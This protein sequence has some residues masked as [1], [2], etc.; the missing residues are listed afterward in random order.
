MPKQ[1]VLFLTLRVFSATGGIEKVC[2]AAA[3]ALY[4][5][6]KQLPQQRDVQV[7]SMYDESTQIDSRYL[8]VDQFHGF[9][10]KRFQFMLAAMKAARSSDIVLLSHVNLLL[11]VP[12]IWLLAPRK[13][14]MLIAHGIE[15][16]RSLPNWKRFLLRRLAQILCVS[17]FTQ[18]QLTQQHGVS[19]NNLTVVWNG[20][21]PFL[22][23][24]ASAEEG[25]AFR[26]TL[27]IPDSALVMMTLTRIS[28]T[29]GYKGY[30]RLIELMPRLIE[31]YPSLYY[32]L[33][34]KHDPSEKA[35]L[36]QLLAQHGC[37]ERV[38]FTG[39]LPDEQVPACFAASDVYVMPSKKEGFGLVFIE[40]LFY[41]K[42]V[43]AGG[44]DGSV[45]ALLQGKL[46]HLV[47]PDHPESILAGVCSALNHSPNLLA[48]RTLVEQHYGFVAY[49][50]RLLRA[51]N[52]A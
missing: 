31:R 24:P 15:V 21:D 42:A 20:L 23:A 2:R 34:G 47:D 41:G 40:A 8:A 16:W 48:Q 46:G 27:G 51:L 1:R 9:G 25:R 19:A 5:W 29:E 13:K 39:F 33:V 28:S 49:Q 22:L 18:D 4:S 38:K 50:H 7:Y 14:I 10:L 32:V 12:L 30:D 11:V 37:T 45:D 44:K 36:D 52:L 17:Q 26:A 43:V 3:F 6:Q 35:R